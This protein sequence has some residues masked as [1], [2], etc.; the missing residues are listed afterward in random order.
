[1][2]E[3]RSAHLSL[4][5]AALAVSFLLSLLMVLPHSIMYFTGLQNV[6][7]YGDQI[8]GINLDKTAVEIFELS[9]KTGEGTWYRTEMVGGE[10]TRVFPEMAVSEDGEVYVVEERYREGKG[11]SLSVARWNRKKNR[12]EYTAVLPADEVS[13]RTLVDF[14]IQNGKYCFLFYHRTEENPEDYDTYAMTPEGSWASLQDTEMPDWDFSITGVSLR[15]M[16]YPGVRLPIRRILLNILTGWLVLLAGMFLL[17]TAWQWWKTRQ[18]RPGLLVRL[19]TGTAALFFLLTPVF[20]VCMREYLF[21]YISSNEIYA[22]TME[23]ELYSRIMDRTVLDD[24]AAGRTN[25]DTDEFREL[26]RSEEGISAAVAWYQEDGVH[27]IGDLFDNGAYWSMMTEGSLKDCVDE[28]LEAGKPKDFLYA[29]RRG[30]H[31]V[32]MRPEKT[33]SGLDTV[34]CVQTL[35]RKDLQNFHYILLQVLRT[36]GCMGMAVLATVFAVLALSLSPL[37]RLRNAVADL[38]EGKL[39]TRLHVRGHNELAAVSAEFNLMAEE[40]EKTREGTDIYRK[41]YEAFW[42]MDLMRRIT[43]K[44]ISA[45]LK[46]GTSLRTEAVVLEVKTGGGTASGNRMGKE[47]LSELLRLVKSRGGSAVRF[48]EEQLTAVFTCPARD[49][50]LCAVLMQRMAEE[51]NGRTFCMGMASGPVGLRV[52]EVLDSKAILAK[53]A[54]DAGKLC[55]LA[56]IWQ[57]GLIATESVYRE[58]AESGSEFHFRLLGRV[59][60]DGWYHGEELYELLDAATPECRKIREDSAGAFEDGVRAYAA[61]DY[62][63]ARIDMIA[64]LAADAEDRAARS[65]CMNCDR[66]EPPVICQAER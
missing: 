62:F 7:Y 39:D 38:A 57:E 27:M 13:D 60:V 3:R 59:C 31:A 42:P 18:Y 51:K 37:K 47:M 43:G 9:S 12:L 15:S 56:E 65:Y 63:R 29:G 19:T 1:M 49:A 20:F 10:G 11:T 35:M 4:I 23:A 6:K 46:T 55:D 53:I 36:C 41:F 14:C 22:C 44:S 28:V 24:L 40:L 30:I 66:K 26:L 33:T 21:N 17:W 50:L 64:C 16:P 34:L 45:S 5:A 8:F 54:E 48:T 32:V 61:K 25:P 58:A 52:A 2:E